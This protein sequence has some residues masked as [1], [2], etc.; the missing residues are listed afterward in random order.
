M[1]HQQH[2]AVERKDVIK[3]ILLEANTILDPHHTVGDTYNDRSPYKQKFRRGNFRGN[4][5]GNYGVRNLMEIEVNQKYY[6]GQDI[7]DLL[8]VG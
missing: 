5:R 4:Y 2:T 8:A 7:L 3:A 6:C 1:E